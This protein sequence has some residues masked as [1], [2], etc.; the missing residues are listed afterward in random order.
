MSNDFKRGIR[1]YLETSDYSKGIESMVAATKKYETKLS[2]LT[3]ESKKMTAAGLNSGK[4]WDDL[5]RKIKLHE[6]QLKKT[7]N[8]E[9]EFRDKMKETDRVLKNLAGVS[10]NDLL[11]VKTQLNRELREATRGTQKYNT[12]LEQH[13]R[14]TISMA[15]AQNE[16]NTEI[17][18]QG[19]NWAKAAGFLNNYWVMFTGFVAI[20]IGASMTFRKIA[21]DVAKMDDVYSDVMK[22]TGLTRDEVLALNEELKKMDTRTSREELNKLAT[23]AGKLGIVGSKNIL[24]FVDAGNQIRVALG[25]DLGED[26]IKNIGKMVG[27]FEKST[28]E[29]QG[30]GLKEQMLAV[31]SAVNELGATSSANEDYLVQFAGRLGGVATQAGI[32][33]DSILGFAS[34]LDQ[35]MQQVEMSAT[36]LQQFIMKLMGDPAKFAK[37]AGLEV[38]NFSTLLN[39]DANAAIKQVLRAL[40]EKGGFQKLIP[41]FQEMGLDGA[42]ATGVLSSMANSIDKID[43]AQ[44]IANQ[45]MA[46]GVS[47]TNE[48]EIKNNNLAAKLEKARKEFQEVALKLG[49]SLN[50][51]LLESTKWTTM[52][53]KGLA[54][55][56][57]ILKEYKGSIIGIV[58]AIGAYT[59]ILKS[60]IILDKIE[61]II[62]D[63]KIY[64][65]RLRIALTN[66]ATAAEIRLLGSQEALNASLKRNMWGLIAAAIAFAI[67]KLIEYGSKMRE[68]TAATQIFNDIYSDQKTLI[69]E[70]SKQVLEEKSNL[71][72]LVNAII[73]TNNNNVLRSQLISE[74]KEKYP[75]FLSFIGNEKITNDLLAGALK[76]VNEQ[77]DI[78]IQNAALAAQSQAYDN[79]S[80]KAAQRRIEI[81]EEIKTLSYENGEGDK[82][83]IENLQKE[84][85]QLQRNITAYGQ[86]SAKYRAE[87]V[88]NEQEIKKMNTSAGVE[89]MMK[90]KT[91][92]ILF[93]QKVLKNSKKGEDAD[94]KEKLAA[95]NKMFEFYQ[96]KLYGLREI[97]AKAKKK[98]NRTVKGGGV[99]DPEKDKTEKDKKLKA[100]LEALEAKQLAEQN[101]LKQARLDNKKSEEEYATEM[102][103]IEV[104]YLLE[105]QKLYKKGSK[106]YEDLESKVLDIEITKKKTANEIHIK[107]VEDSYK[108]IEQVTTSYEQV[109][110][111]RLQGELEN[112]TKTKEQYNTAI[113]DLEVSV[114]ESRLRNATD[115]AE[116][117]RDATFNT[118][119]DKKKAVDAATAAVTAANDAWLKAKKAGIKDETTLEKERLAEIDRIRQNLGLDREKL[120]Y[121]KSLKAL[122]EKL[123]AEKIAEVDQAEYIAAFKKQ[124]AVEY[125][126]IAVDITNRIASAVQGYQQ[127]ETNNLEAEKNKQLA[128]AGDNADARAVIERDFAQKELDLKKKQS[129]A[130]V[131]IQIAQAMAAGALGI[132]NIWAIHGVNPIL[133]GI[134]TALEVATVAVQVG[135][136]VSANAA[137]QSQ[138]LD[139]SSSPSSSPASTG[140]RIVSPQAADGR[141]DV[142]GADDGRVYRNVPYTGVAR[143]GMVTRPT[144]MG[145]RGDEL[146]V[147]NPTLRNLRMNAPWVIDTIRKS[148]VPQRADGNYNAIGNAPTGGSSPA[149]DNSAMMAAVVDK[150]TQL[151]QY[152][153]DNGIDAFVILSQ[154]EKQQALRDKSLA[155]GSLK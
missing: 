2:E 118:E 29:L 135:N 122:K 95:A 19:N 76:D 125:A 96:M 4:A 94:I 12:I 15:K 68:T 37:L 154:L 77:Y 98:P 128:L 11:K 55:L 49:E 47:I 141:W 35:D 136:I 81:E 134:I 31:G 10:Y 60:K 18:C 8:S 119:A 13:K 146:V 32:G 93:Y 17:G 78:K 25:E 33:M 22:T 117:I 100:D 5:Q 139:S 87:A 38:K 110:R 71:T 106:E 39:T 102:L 97:E 52:L 84:D 92:E 116:L 48:Y 40:H 142:I 30:I 153:I 111:E 113:A 9:K 104:K 121:M 101:I 103:D 124:K 1:V 82:K 70:H 120:G 24:D 23:E 59:L 67:V 147:D 108:A 34:A 62:H 73:N 36:A 114:A 16:M 130:N 85:L 44:R 72:S 112:K 83:R 75:G 144:L 80:I 28:K 43:K 65:L 150:N 21:E 57:G 7:A 61:R 129:S 69:A 115:Y 109:E 50:P 143:T 63:A 86:R 127:I 42:R 131:G 27:V 74:L 152:L 155:K 14:V 66:Q 89:E 6:T 138:T 148:R 145:E 137:I 20:V 91:D 56:P 46:A 107:D 51:A 26:A 132:A 53:V 140:A 79:A 41:I 58:S 126:Q 64:G 105:K 133:A 90:L 54:N 45:S 123:N 88:R 99:V 151:L 149:V 3:E